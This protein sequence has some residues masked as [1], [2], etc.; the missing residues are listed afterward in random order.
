MREKALIYEGNDSNQ[1]WQTTTS[2]NNYDY[3]LFPSMGKHVKE[4]KMSVNQHL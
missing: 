1:P 3:S 2:S 4:N